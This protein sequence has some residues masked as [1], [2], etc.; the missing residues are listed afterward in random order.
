M[1]LLCFQMY[2][3]FL[4]Y[5]KLYAC[6]SVR[7]FI[8]RYSCSVYGSQKKTLDPLAPRLELNWLKAAKC[9]WLRSELGSLQ[10]LQVLLI[11]K[12][13]LQ[14]LNQLFIYKH[15]LLQTG[16]GSMKKVPCGHQP[17]SSS[18][19]KCLLETYL[20]TFQLFSSGKL[21]PL[22]VFNTLGKLMF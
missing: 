13:C 19:G 8:Y 17:A 1:I 21:F 18:D 4:F 3:L 5:F 6:S 15:S 14:T 7:K 16:S 22:F 10:E 11:S 12:P 20:E 2:L 9:V